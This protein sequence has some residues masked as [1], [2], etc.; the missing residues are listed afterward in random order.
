MDIALADKIA[1]LRLAALTATPISRRKLAHY[2]A[3]LRLALDG[4]AA[5]ALAAEL[6]RLLRAIHAWP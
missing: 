4:R 3:T 2:R 5:P 1:S 6:T